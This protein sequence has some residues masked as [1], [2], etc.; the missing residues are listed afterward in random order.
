M[1]D[2]K[3]KVLE[4]SKQEPKLSRAEIARQAG[5]SAPYVTQTLGAERKYKPRVKAEA[6]PETV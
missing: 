4:L 3:N 5:C 6:S 2:K 1:T